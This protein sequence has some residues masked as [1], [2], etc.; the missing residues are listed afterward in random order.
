MPRVTNPRVVGARAPAASRVSAPQMS[1]NRDAL[2]ALRNAYGNR[3]ED[4]RWGDAHRLRFANPLLSR[5]PLLGALAG[6]D[7]E[8]DGGNETVN[9]G[10]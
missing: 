4:W 6:T 9:R 2:A 3:I 5:L 8:T 10:A 1:S 7:V